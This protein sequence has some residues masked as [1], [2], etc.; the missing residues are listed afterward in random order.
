VGLDHYETRSWRGWH[1]HTALA[2]LALA[3]LA[4]GAAKEGTTRRA[5]RSSP[6]ASPSSAAS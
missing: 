5:L 1:R 4:V 2:P 3:A 6:S